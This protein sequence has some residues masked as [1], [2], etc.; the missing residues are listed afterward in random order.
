MQC[1]WRKSWLPKKC[2]LWQHCWAIRPHP[3]RLQQPCTLGCQLSTYLLR[4]PLG[5]HL[6]TQGQPLLLAVLLKASK[7]RLFTYARC[8]HFQ[9]DALIKLLAPDTGI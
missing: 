7:S 3:C 9:H 5:P 2:L 8:P 4:A 1:P 6:A